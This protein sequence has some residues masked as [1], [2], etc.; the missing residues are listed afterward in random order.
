MHEQSLVKALLK[1]VDAI[2]RQHGAEQV[3]EVRIEVG[4]LSGVEPLLLIAAFKRLAPRSPA[5]AA[6]LVIDQVDLMAE[7]KSCKQQFQIKNFDFRC[8]TCGNNVRVIRGDEFQLVSVSLLD[9]VFGARGNSELNVQ[10][11]GCKQEM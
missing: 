2:R 3:A 11:S 5:K 1:Q 6:M 10:E 8:P 4:P 7:C 9:P